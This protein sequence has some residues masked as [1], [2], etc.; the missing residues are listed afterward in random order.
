MWDEFFRRALQDALAAL[1][2]QAL[3]VRIAWMFWVV[4]EP[5]WWWLIAGI[6]G[7]VAGYFART[8]LLADCVARLRRV[9]VA[10]GI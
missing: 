1:P 2:N 3:G 10:C 4:R 5:V 8:P 9:R 7:F 6:A